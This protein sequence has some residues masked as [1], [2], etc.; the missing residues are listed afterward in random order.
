MAVPYSAIFDGF[1]LD[2]HNYIHPFFV[3]LKVIGSCHPS[4]FIRKIFE[5]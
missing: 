3:K 5:V 1:Q 2:N 4:K